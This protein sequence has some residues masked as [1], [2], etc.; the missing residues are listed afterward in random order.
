MSDFH[1]SPSALSST[2]QGLNNLSNVLMQRHESQLARM[3]RTQAAE[4]EL[5][6]RREF[7]ALDREVQAQLREAMSTRFQTGSTI[8]E[9]QPI[10]MGEEREDFLITRLADIRER[11]LSRVTTP[12][13]RAAFESRMDQLEMEYQESFIEKETNMLRSWNN[14]QLP[15]VINETAA[16]YAGDPVR[17]E[18][19]MAIVSDL[20]Q[21]AVADGSYTPEAANEQWGNARTIFANYA[22]NEFNSEPVDEEGTPF[23]PDQWMEA[24]TATTEYID[25]L[26]NT[27]YIGEE[28]RSEMRR[29]AE[30]TRFARVEAHTA[31]L[32]SRYAGIVIRNAP[33]WNA[34]E[35]TKEGMYQTL[36]AGLHSDDGFKNLPRDM[37]S[38]VEGAIWTQLGRVMTSEGDRSRSARDIANSMKSDIIAEYNAIAARNIDQADEWLREQLSDDEYWTGSQELEDVR[39]ELAGDTNDWQNINSQIMRDARQRFNEPY[40]GGDGTAVDSYVDMRAADLG[41]PA[42]AQLMNSIKNAIA[43]TAGVSYEGIGTASNVITQEHVDR[44]FADL[45]MSILQGAYE[46]DAE[47]GILRRRSDRDRALAEM[48]ETSEDLAKSG[49]DINATQRALQPAFNSGNTTAFRRVLAPIIQQLVTNHQFQVNE[50]GVQDKAQI[51]A[52]VRDMLGGATEEETA[53]LDPI[54]S[55]VMGTLEFSM[56]SALHNVQVGYTDRSVAIK[57]ILMGTG[58]T[59]IVGVET[60]ARNRSGQMFDYMD[61]YAPAMSDDGRLMLQR[62]QPDGLGWSKLGPLTELRRL[63]GGRAPG[64]SNAGGGAAQSPRE[65][66]ERVLGEDFQNLTAGQIRRE[67]SSIEGLMRVGRASGDDMDRLRSLTFLRE[68]RR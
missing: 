34:E 45:E 41:L 15:V 36:T 59:M 56:G 30:E 19:G 20:L 35:Q 32:T 37:Q 21:A 42:D 26:Y 8:P 58:G 44:V 55:L 40:R 2:A 23:G 52:S 46:L 50:R 4:A 13:G 11:T 3:Q 10:I 51:E 28:E 47:T 29:I 67:I 24:H 12:S 39:R 9:G 61:Y 22:F 63:P 17:R 16:E 48:E 6:A 49:I 38:M 27:E 53:L 18:Q 64:E 60:S 54:V 7:N 66:A 25:Q 57:D 5:A 31:G 14:S 65:F 1:N 43:D 33:I 62:Y 68:S